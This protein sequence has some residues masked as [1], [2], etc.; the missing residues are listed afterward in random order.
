MTSF[1]ELLELHRQFDD[2]FF[3]DQ[4]VPIWIGG[5]PGRSILVGKR[6]QGGLVSDRHL[7]TLNLD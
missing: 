4:R 1:N 7:T 5:R 3:E 6:F 2:I